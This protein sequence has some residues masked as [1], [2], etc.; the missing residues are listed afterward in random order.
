M[1]KQKMPDQML[2]GRLKHEIART[3]FPH[4]VYLKQIW[5]NVQRV[6]NQL[7]R[8]VVLPLSGQRRICT[9]LERL[10]QSKQTFVIHRQRVHSKAQMNVLEVQAA[11]GIH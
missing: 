4:A 8:G 11:Q 6:G 1:K 5:N 2:K 3:D 10:H 7:A 9:G